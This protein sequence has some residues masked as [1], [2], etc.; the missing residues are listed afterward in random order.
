MN[1]LKL[2][3]SERNS[4]IVK[5]PLTEVVKNVLK[6]FHSSGT[7]V[8]TQ[9]STTLSN[10]M[11]EI[12]DHLD[13]EPEN[14]E[15]VTLDNTQNNLLIKRNNIVRKPQE[16]LLN[17]GKLT[18][19]KKSRGRVK[20]HNR[21]MKLG[22]KS[23]KISQDG[24]S[25][26]G[27]NKLNASG[28]K[29]IDCSDYVLVE[30]PEIS[31]LCHES[32]D[33]KCDK[34]DLKK[35]DKPSNTSKCDDSIEPYDL[36]DNLKVNSLNKVS[37]EYTES[38][39]SK[40]TSILNKTTQK[41]YISDEKKVSKNF[42]ISVSGDNRSLVGPKKQKARRSWSTKVKD[43]LKDD[44]RITS[45]DIL[46]LVV[47]KEIFSNSITCSK[48]SKEPQNIPEEKMFK[49]PLKRP[50]SRK[51]FTG[52]NPLPVLLKSREIELKS[53][54]R[55][56]TGNKI[57]PLDDAISLIGSTTIVE[58]DLDNTLTSSY[59]FETNK[60][61]TNEEVNKVEQ[62]LNT[63]NMGT[64]SFSQNS[65]VP[66]IFRG[67]CYKHFFY[68]SCLNTNKCYNSHDLNGPEAHNFVMSKPIFYKTVYK[69]FTKAFAK[70]DMK[71]ELINVVQI[72][73]NNNYGN[74]ALT[75]G[76]TNVLDSLTE[77]DL[78]TFEDSVEFLLLGI[79]IKQY[80]MLGS[81]IFE[82]ICNKG[83]VNRYWPI[84]RR[85]V[86]MGERML[87]MLGAKFLINL[88]KPPVNFQLC[89]EA[90]KLLQKYN[91]INTDKVAPDVM[92]TFQQLCVEDEPSIPKTNNLYTVSKSPEGLRIQLYNEQTSP[93]IPVAAVHSPSTSKSLDEKTRS[94]ST[95][96]DSSNSKGYD[97]DFEDEQDLTELKF[98]PPASSQNDQN[99]FIWSQANPDLNP[100]RSFIDAKKMMGINLNET[101]GSTTDGIFNFNDLD[102]R[103]CGP[104]DSA[105][106]DQTSSCASSSNY[107]VVKDYNKEGL[108]YDPTTD[109]TPVPKKSKIMVTL[110]DFGRSNEDHDSNLISG[111]YSGSETSDTYV[112]DENHYKNI[113]FVGGRKVIEIEPFHTRNN[114]K[115]PELPLFGK[116][117]EFNR[118]YKLNVNLHNL[119]LE[120]IDNIDLDKEDI[121]ALNNCIKFSDGQSFLNLLHKYKGPMT[122]QNFISM[123]LAHLIGTNQMMAK[124]FFN[125]LA[126]I[127]QSD[128]HYYGQVESR[129]ILEVISMNFLFELDKRNL[130]S[131]ITHLLL[132]FSNW[133][134]LVSSRL[135][136][137][138]T[139]TLIGR[140][141]FIAKFMLHTKPELTYEILICENFH[142]L[143]H[144]GRWPCSLNPLVNGGT[145]ADL[146]LR[147]TILTIFFTKSYLLNIIVVIQLYK[148]ALK[149]G[150]YHFDVRPFINK[151]MVVLINKQQWILLKQ[152][153]H[154]MDLFW[155]HLAKNTM[156]AFLIVTFK[157]INVNDAYKLFNKCVERGIYQNL[158]NTEAI[159]HTVHVKT[160]MLDEEIKLILQ[161]YFMKL[162]QLKNLPPRSETLKFIIGLPNQMEDNQDISILNLNRS[163][164]VI[165]EVLRYYLVEICSLKSK[166]SVPT[167]VEV[168]KDDLIDFLEKPHSII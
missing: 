42:K 44:I 10:D 157:Y 22:K 102:L 150:I 87:P 63:Q 119:Y 7:N 12:E 165:N 38:S 100:S 97:T 121:I 147:N 141:L 73:F 28:G 59:E 122:I 35:C 166:S 99:S 33:P 101:R 2:S 95:N 50:P 114:D 24:Y 131:A 133:D 108:L 3:K 153:L 39:N 148:T 51:K 20:N 104:F 112:E 58:K 16:A 128:P 107:Q 27:N 6:N 36:T 123:T 154:E 125:L 60:L 129:V 78:G 160:N 18:I 74:V 86:L 72:F 62:W 109:Y 89:R 155:R 79:S 94:N 92:S 146:K 56:I 88:M 48:S 120:D 8:I 84:I 40:V 14:E 161:Q 11:L 138:K 69:C 75:E 143:E 21:S 57:H 106:V 52:N 98:E 167:L 53:I 145:Q 46:R 32:I 4:V 55:I 159:V 76:V 65:G 118:W 70:R 13:Y 90:N 142:L 31:Q 164:Q 91:F 132:M 139:V 144:C 152:I 130:Y 135:F 117:N 82:I 168:E 126:S 23:D 83:D 34:I 45:M 54:E 96:T 77:T 15:S 5:L 124:I 103:M 1:F 49:F 41:L 17:H 68:N 115:P 93:Q 149:T 43:V 47:N 136:I 37:D 163:V 113:Y 116:F 67:L 66:R 30:E 111:R 105:S 158:D 81:I 80:P 64:K 29:T 151:M 137:N 26:F 110:N 127:E 134:T 71:H 19:T 162:Q 85:L 61:N 156:R 140:Y 9:Y 25:N